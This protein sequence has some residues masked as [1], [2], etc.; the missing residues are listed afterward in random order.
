MRRVAR[1][2]HAL[3]HKSLHPAALELV[4]RYPLKIE[5]GVP[6][7][8]LDARTHILRQPLDGRIG[9]RPK[10]QVDAPDIVGLAVQQR[11]LP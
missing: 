10:L 6:Q 2:D 8:A 4:D 9:S 5:I 1:E 11:G 7:H 3:M